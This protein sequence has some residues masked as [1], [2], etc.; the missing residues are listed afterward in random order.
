VP[1]LLLEIGVEEVPAS[2]LAPAVREL[3]ERVMA[4][5]AELHIEAEGL[6][7]YETPRRLAVHVAH[8]AA[9]QASREVE[10]RG[11]AV[12]AAYDA[13]GKLTKAGSGFL[14]G[15]GASEADLIRIAGKKGDYIGVRLSEGGGHTADLL[16]SHLPRLIAALPFPKAMR[17]GNGTWRFARPVHW[18]LAVFAGAVVPFEVD[19]LASGGTTRGHRFL[20]PAA[21]AVTRLEGYLQ[22]LRAASVE[23]DPAARAAAIGAR[24]EALGVEA[25]GRTVVEDDLL[26]EVAHLVEHPGCVIGRFDEDFLAVPREVLV[27]SMAKNQRY[28]PVEGGDGQLL[29]AFV[30]VT[31]SP[32][33]AADNV[34]AGNERVLRARLADAR[35]FW[36]EDRKRTLHSRRPD[37]DAVA[38]HERLGSL[39]AKVA[40][41]EALAVG[42][43]EAVT[44]VAED[45]IRRAV[46]LAKA[47]LTTHMVI[48]FPKLQGVMGRHYAAHDG[49]PAAVCQAIE[50]HY[51]PR[52]A[53]DRLPATD[54]GRLVAVADRL[55][56]VCGGF[57]VGLI[58]SGSQDPFGLRRAGLGLIQIVLDGGW[59]LDLWHWIDDALTQLAASGVTVAAAARGQ[60]RDFLGQRLQHAVVQEGLPEDVVRAVLAMGSRHPLRDRARAQ[61]LA[62]LRQE[63][64]FEDFA[65]SFK[66]VQRIIPADFVAVP[67]VDG[68]VLVE[69]AEQALLAEQRRV[70]EE[71]AP[72]RAAG[73][74]GAILARLVTLRPAVDRFFDDI[75]VMAD[76]PDL[77][78]ARLTLLC[79]VRALFD[80]LADLSQLAVE[81]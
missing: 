21:V 80:G 41:M 32:E 9:T 25:G 46:Q 22:T 13:D 56:A 31:N 60:V 44:T 66:R 45:E 81:G 3:G 15:A 34:R 4:L 71:V 63:P 20:A 42:I 11:P 10:R 39:G 28:F 27:T 7:T 12:A 78:A 36:D 79:R 62:A 53:G 52:F 77:R 48:E 47:D 67:E 38:L 2:Y 23:P 74:Y 40:R 16:A 17:W 73:D 69:A 35:F 61:A 50:E 64:T 26:D 76:E 68:S 55:D 43:G 8:V 58:P 5:L 59:D 72:L 30:A 18:I 75:L 37:L 65:L 29:P 1:E 57:A 14:Q 24:A 54:L 19:G 70:A 51:R 49:E 33:S 6:T